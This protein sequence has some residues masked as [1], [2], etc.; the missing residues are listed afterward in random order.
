M[1]TTKP[2]VLVVPNKPWEAP[3]VLREYDTIEEAKAQAYA[4]AQRRITKDPTDPER[5]KVFGM[6]Y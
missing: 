5:Y 4:M 3:W 2:Y 1:S 6:V